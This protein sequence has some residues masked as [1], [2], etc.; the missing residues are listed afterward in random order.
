M[1]SIGEV[2]GGLK[3]YLAMVFLQ[4]GYAGMF[5]VSVASLKRGMSNYV[6]VVY[7]NAVAVIA[8]GPFALWLE[9]LLVSPPPLVFV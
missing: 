1:G 3:P 9:G 4:C 6:L 2:W 7:R 5:V 8:V